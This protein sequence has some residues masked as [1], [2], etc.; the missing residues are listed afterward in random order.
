MAVT[1][2]LIFM[3][4]VIGV[5]LFKGKFF[6]C[7][8]LSMNNNETC[9]GEFVS[10]QD[11]DI[12]KPIVEERIWERSEFH[13][14]NIMHAMLTLFVVSTFEGWP[15]ILYVSID[16]NEADVGPKQDYRPIVF[17]FYFVYI[18]ILAF[19]MINIFV[20]FVIVTFQSE[21]EADFKD[22]PLDKNQRNCIEF[23]LN[24]RPIKL[25]IP[26]NPIQY[27]LWAFATSPLCEN[28]VFLAIILNTI[29]LAMKVYHQPE[30]YTDF[31]DVLNLIFT[32]FFVGEF[33]LK[34][35]AYRFKNYFRDPWNGFDFFIVVGSVIDLGFAQLAPDA[36]VMSIS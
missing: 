28:T 22:C 30:W 7:T 18:I 8:D 9:Q 15:G 19:F 33:I 10:Y 31:L 25:Y 4:G 21:G 34:F 3:F 35:G 5:Q 6:M 24:A 14:D 29:S 16:S 17:M 20:G 36:E 1:V 32:F 2:L 11:G 12:N 26:K 23:S 13:Y 27:K